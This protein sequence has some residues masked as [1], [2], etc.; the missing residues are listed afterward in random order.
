MTKAQAADLRAEW[1]EQGIPPSSCEHLNQEAR[2]VTLSEDGYVTSTYHCRQCGE[3]IVRTYKSISFRPGIHQSIR[4]SSVFRHWC[5]S[6]LAVL[7][8]RRAIEGERIIHPGEG[9]HVQNSGD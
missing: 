4:P 2:H 5:Y 8:K 7:S 1:K 6:V 3:E 9:Y